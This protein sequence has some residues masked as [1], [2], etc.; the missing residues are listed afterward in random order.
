MG[1]G[2]AAAVI[3][4]IS[5]VI[6]HSRCNKGQQEVF[7]KDWFVLPDLHGVISQKI[8]IYISIT[9]ATPNLV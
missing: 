8:G 6:W 7:P 1:S 4:N 2:H 3:I 5:A 9:M